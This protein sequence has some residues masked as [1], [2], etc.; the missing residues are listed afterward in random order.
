MT[1]QGKAFQEPRPVGPI[2]SF[3][4]EYYRLLSQAPGYFLKRI[5]ESFRKPF[6]FTNHE[7]D[8]ARSTNVS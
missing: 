3:N 8:N 2:N 4:A 7:R 5:V 6:V 1:N